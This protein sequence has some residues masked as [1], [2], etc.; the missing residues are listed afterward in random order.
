LAD[1]L[2]DSLGYSLADCSADSLA[3]FG[4]WLAL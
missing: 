4:G 3:C 2:A 1:S